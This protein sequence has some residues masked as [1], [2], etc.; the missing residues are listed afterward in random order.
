MKKK[1]IAVA[2]ISGLA[3]TTAVSMTWARGGYGGGGYGYNGACPMVQGGYALQLDPAVK[4][5]MDTFY[6]DTSD[7]RRQIVVKQAERRA[8]MQ[9]TSPDPAAVSKV[10]GELFDLHNSMRAK[11]DAVG[12]SQYMGPRMMNGGPM[13]GGYGHHGKRDFGG[14]QGGRMMGGPNN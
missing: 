4:E 10:S 5:K 11:A 12:I 1:I 8:L 13:G 3:L 2:L 7:L 6:N 9:N 14:G